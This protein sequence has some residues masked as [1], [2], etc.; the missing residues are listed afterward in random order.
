MGF[1]VHVRLSSYREL[2]LGIGDF[3][4]L[5]SIVELYCISL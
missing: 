5:V 1:S 2:N 3:L 4:V